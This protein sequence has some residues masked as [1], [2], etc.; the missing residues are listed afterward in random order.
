MLLEYPRLLPDLTPSSRF[1]GPD[2]HYWLKSLQLG[3]GDSGKAGGIEAR[4]KGNF[5]ICAK[6]HMSKTLKSSSSQHLGEQ[7]QIL[8]VSDRP[9]ILRGCY[10]RE[11]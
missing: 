9:L 5:I 1:L 8:R 7:M 10:M 11:I 4:K 2:H 6:H 3:G